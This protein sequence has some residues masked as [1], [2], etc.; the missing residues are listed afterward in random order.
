MAQG[1]Q[2][3][4]KRKWSKGRF[5][6]DFLSHVVITQTRITEDGDT[7][8]TEADDTRVTEKTRNG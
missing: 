6:R 8:I 3:S 5:G 2:R 7:R 1:L 4:F